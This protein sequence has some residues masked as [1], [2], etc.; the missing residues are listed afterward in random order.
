[1]SSGAMD[2][3]NPNVGGQIIHAFSQQDYRTTNWT[4]AVIGASLPTTL[5]L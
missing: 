3:K 4:L 5:E 2:A 1:M